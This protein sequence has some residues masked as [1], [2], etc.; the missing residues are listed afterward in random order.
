MIFCLVAS[1]INWESNLKGM[2]DSALAVLSGFFSEVRYRRGLRIQL[3]YEVIGIFMK[4]CSFCHSLT[5]TYISIW[6]ILLDHGYFLL[7]G[8]GGGQKKDSQHHSRRDAQHMTEGSRKAPSSRGCAY[9]LSICMRVIALFLQTADL[10]PKWINMLR[11]CPCLMPLKSYFHRNGGKHLQR[12]YII[13][14]KVQ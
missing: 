3:V 4:S 1:L 6:E 9:S 10:S 11:T 13:F 7:L 2:L 8:G 5:N 14:L 12:V